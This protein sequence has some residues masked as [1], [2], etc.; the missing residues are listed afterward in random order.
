MA[1][2]LDP[3]AGASA[4]DALA[5]QIALLRVDESGATPQPGS[6]ARLWVSPEY[7]ELTS[8]QHKLNAAAGVAESREAT[9]EAAGLSPAASA[10]QWLLD[11][12]RSVVETVTS[13]YVTVLA[14]LTPYR[15]RPP[16]AKPW[17][18]LT[19]AAFLIGDIG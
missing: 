15:R 3:L 17:H 5:E 16:K 12:H 2:E 1:R 10:D 18:L 6:V 19:K 4:A 14:L 8:E 13:T 11:G 7:D 9:V